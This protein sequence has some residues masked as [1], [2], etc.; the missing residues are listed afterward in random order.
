MDRGDGHEGTPEFSIVC[1]IKDEADLIPITLPSFYSVNPYEVLLCLDKPAPEEVIKAIHKVARICGAERITRI[2]EVERRDDFA[3][4][5][6]WVRRCGFSKTKCDIIL[7]TDI[8]I[9]LN[10]KIRNYLHLIDDEVKLVS[11]SKFPYPIDFRKCTAWLVQKVY[12]HNSFTGLYAF[13]KKAWLET[14]DEESL[15]KIPRGEDT[16]LHEYLTKKYK[17]KFIAGIKNIVLRPKESSRYQFL[18]GWNRW[19]IRKT[20]VPRILLSTFLYF[21]PFLLA[22]YLKARL[23]EYAGD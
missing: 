6:A 14:E 9:I 16:H 21:R 15:K 18:M 23:Y 22:G 19:K 11:F 10:P 3:F 20:S 7:T 4:H 5:Q 2:I 8:D 12:Y 13:S 1:P 17:A